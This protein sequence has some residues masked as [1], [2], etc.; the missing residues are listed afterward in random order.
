MTV[1]EMASKME[2]FKAQIGL[3]AWIVQSPFN[4]N[5][6]SLPKLER[7]LAAYKNGYCTLRPRLWGDWRPC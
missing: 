7:R 4:R 3:V 6:P 2:Y 5:S 1:S